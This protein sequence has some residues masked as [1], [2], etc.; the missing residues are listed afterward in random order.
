MGDVLQFPNRQSAITERVDA[1]V[2]CILRLQAAS[3]L[4]AD[5]IRAEALGAR[6]DVASLQEAMH[7]ILPRADAPFRGSARIEEVWNR[8]EGL[9]DRITICALCFYGDSAGAER[10]YAIRERLKVTC[11]STLPELRLLRS[12]LVSTDCNE[13]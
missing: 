6:L 4:T 7:D 1:C 10:S 9:L 5:K 11:R 12:L 2:T 8:L 13:G 3:G